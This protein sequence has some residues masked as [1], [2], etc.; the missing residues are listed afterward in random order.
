MV[1]AVNALLMISVALY[2]LIQSVS[3]ILSGGRDIEFGPAIAYAVIVLAPTVVIGGL[4]HR[5]NS[6]IDSALVAMDVKGWI[7]A[8]GVTA[9]LLVAFTL[10]L[11][12]DGTRLAWAMPYV[13][14]VV[15]GRRHRAHPGA[16]G[17]AASGARRARPRD[18]AGPARGGR[19][20]GSA[21]R[22]G[23]G[24]HRVLRLHRSGRR[25]RRVET[26]FLVPEDLPPRPLADWDRIRQRV[27]DEL[28]GNDPNHWITVFFTT[29]RE[30]T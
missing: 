11:L 17:D 28:A 18:S 25:S 8:G 26:T 6:H 14:P 24:L 9:A 27:T 13:D 21:G 30:L 29:K 10:G 16:G 4:E 20:G 23:G 15:I 7:M 3:A 2:A 5:A 1:L 19:A 22:R 12:V